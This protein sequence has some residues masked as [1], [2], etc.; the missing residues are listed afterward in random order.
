M[1]ADNPLSEN[2][3]SYGPTTQGKSMR[4]ADGPYGNT[5]RVDIE[6]QSFVDFMAHYL[7]GTSFDED[8]SEDE[9]QCP[10]QVSGE[11][12]KAFKRRQHAQ[13]M[14][15]KFKLFKSARTGL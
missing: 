10:Y 6:A 3:P 12:S 9:S 7:Q 1:D 15:D 4:A 8:A 14:L 2:E 13:D 5:A 11:A